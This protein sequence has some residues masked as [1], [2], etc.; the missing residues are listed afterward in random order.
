[1]RRLVEPRP[2]P[3]GRSIVL[4]WSIVGLL[5]L[6]T[7]VLTD[8]ITTEGRCK[9]AIIEREKLNT[10]QVERLKE[11]YEEELRNTRDALQWCIQVK[12]LNELTRQIERL[13]PF[14]DK[15]QRKEWN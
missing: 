8:C 2:E 5:V 7:L 12:K 1:M 13:A 3:K 10:R 11:K 15:Q 6:I 14:G 4:F 9:E